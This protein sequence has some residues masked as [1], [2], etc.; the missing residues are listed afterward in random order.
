M[1]LDSFFN[2]YIVLYIAGFTLALVCTQLRNRRWMMFVKFLAESCTGTYMILMGALSGALC[3]YIAGLGGLMQS[4]TPQRYLEKTL[5]PRVI[6]ASLLAA[7][8]TY[9]SYHDPIDLLPVAAIV[10]CR[11]M[12]LNKNAER[13]RLAY[14]LGGFPWMF[15][16]FE[17]ELYPLL[18]MSI[19][20]NQM[21]LIGLIRNRPLKKLRVPGNIDPV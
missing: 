17:R 13:I 1:T 2:P 7:A 20:M 11:F 10:F 5:Y 8:S 3:S 4:A 18:V 15:Y 16:L 19:V 21:F 9:I 14:Y 6:G 12:E